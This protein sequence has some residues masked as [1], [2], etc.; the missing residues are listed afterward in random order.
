MFIENGFVTEEQIS[1]A[2]AVLNT[3]ESKLVTVEDPVAYR[4]P[5]INQVQV[6]DK[7]ELTFARVLGRKQKMPGTLQQALA[8]TTKRRQWRSPQQADAEYR[9]GTVLLQQGRAGE[10]ITA[11]SHAL[12]IDSQHATARQALVARFIEGRRQDDAIRILREGVQNDASQTGLAMILFWQRCCSGTCA[13]RR[14]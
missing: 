14:R 5:G 4:L 6:N 11:F 9:K 2:L 7:I 3:P 1:G 8:G 10:A 12:Q 13:I